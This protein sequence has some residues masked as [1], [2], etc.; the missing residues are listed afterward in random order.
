MAAQR[1]VLVPLSTARM[2]YHCVL[3]LQDLILSRADHNQS[4]RS[5]QTAPAER[6]MGLDSANVQH[7]SKVI[8]A[9]ATSPVCRKLQA[10]W[11]VKGTT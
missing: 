11:A 4:S 3:G 10:M 9:M 8:H 5:E 1:A 7:P 6:V 2:S